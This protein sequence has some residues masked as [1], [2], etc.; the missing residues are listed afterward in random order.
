MQTQL[1][2]YYVNVFEGTE[3][4]YPRMNPEAHHMISAN[5]I[6]EHYPPDA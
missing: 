3:Q 5:I 4:I 2:R 6:T 1:L